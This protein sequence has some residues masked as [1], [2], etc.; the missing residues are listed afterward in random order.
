MNVT[1]RTWTVQ[2]RKCAS[3][4]TLALKPRADVTRSPKQGYQRPQKKDV[5]P[6]NFSKKI[7]DVFVLQ[8]TN[9]KDTHYFQSRILWCAPFLMSTNM[10][11]LNLGYLLCTLIDYLLNIFIDFTYFSSS[12]AIHVAPQNLWH[13]NI[14]SF[15]EHDLHL[16]NKLPHHDT[17][18][19]VQLFSVS[20][21]WSRF[22]SVHAPNNFL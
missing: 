19:P 17:I 8:K 9:G 1:G 3:D 12:R 18:W 14:S 21:T 6:P 22:I 4:S 2:A 20:T 15:I 16:Q 7:S 13:I 5:C 10:H 11:Y